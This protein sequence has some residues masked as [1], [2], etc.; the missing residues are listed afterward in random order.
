[1]TD[2]SK[3]G[4][5]ESILATLASALSGGTSWKQAL[6]AARAAGYAGG[7][8]DVIAWMQAGQWRPAM[9]PAKSEAAPPS[10]IE[11]SR[12]QTTL[13]AAV[14]AQFDYGVRERGGAYFMRGAVRIQEGDAHSVSAYVKGSR[15]YAV[16]LDLFDGELFVD[17]DCPYFADY[18]LCKHIW[19]TIR[20]ADACRYVRPPSGCK[21]LPVTRTSNID[22]EDLLEDGSSVATQEATSPRAANVVKLQDYRQAPPPP[23]W[24]QIVVGLRQTLQQAQ[25][26]KDETRSAD[27]ELLYVVDQAAT[28][29]NRGLVVEVLSRKRK[30]DGTLGAPQTRRIGRSQVPQ[31]PDPADRQIAALLLGGAADQAS[32]GYYYGYEPSLSRFTLPQDLQDVLLPLLCR[33]GRCQLRQQTSE[34]APLLQMDVGPPWE[35]RIEVRPSP[36]GAEYLVRG[37]LH[38]GESRR[39]L[40]EPV[41]LV[42]GGWVFDADR[43]ARLVDFGAFPW[44]G[45]LRQ[46]NEMRVPVAQADGLL[47]EMLRFEQLPPLDLPEELRFEEVRGTPRPHLKVRKAEH[48]CT[49]DKVC[50]DLSFEYGEAVVP[51][52]AGGR[53]TF[54]AERRQ[55]VLRDAAAEAV[56]AAR[57]RQLGFRRNRYDPALELT[58]SKLPRVVRTLVAENWFV[59][60]EGKLYR[61]P[62][63][64]KFSVS[65]GIDWFELRGSLDFEGAS[66]GLPALLA[67]VRK[68]G[69]LVRLDDGSFGL[70]PEEWL[71]RYGLLAGTGVA[72]GDHLRFGR[73][74]AGLLDA[75]LTAQPQADCDAVFS[76][77]REELRRFDAITPC[78][79]PATFSGQLRG[80]QKDGLGWLGFLQRFGFGGCLADDMGLGKTVQVLALLE[81]RRQLR[82]GDGTEQA[83]PSLAVVPRSLI[84]NWKQEAARFTPALRVLDHTGAARVKG[85]HEHFADFD[86]VLTTYGTLLRDV[87]HLRD[88]CFDYVVLDEAQTIKNA[89]TASA[90]AARLLQARHRLCLSGTPIENHVGELWSLFEFLNPGMLGAA[91]VFELSTSGERAPDEHACVLLS[92]AL[93]SFILR[94]TKSQVA[95]DLPDKTEQTVY[96]ELDQTQRALYNELRQHYRD[97]LLARVQRDGVGKAKIQILEALLR[98]RQAAC[99]PGLLDTRRTAESSAKL[100]AL[101]PQLAEVTEEGHKVLV[102]SQFTK[103]LAI[104][105][106]RLDTDRI[107]YEYLDGKTRD[108]EAR[109]NRFQNDPECRLFLISL[110]AGGLGLNLTA[111]EYVFLLDPWWNPAVEAQ[112]VD[113][114]HRIGQTRPVFAY[115]LIARDT[116][117]EKVLELQQTKRELADAIINADNS[118]IRNLSREDLELLLG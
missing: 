70:L 103:F 34:E 7:L 96:C 85:A 27:S 24:K 14:A 32:S 13:T 1:V 71:T 33:S 88:V 104:V 68:G 80:Y 112:A 43:V 16:S 36:D 109:V 8:T 2:G 110:K 47:T 93:R 10:R 108:R 56:A 92:R 29:Q 116:V 19:A 59:E 117:E 95:K 67:A 39:E 74:Q 38:R 57:L 23:R 17:C 30:Q 77:V 31:L 94:R 66:V 83:G 28:M 90:K 113:R 97:A 75:L 64:F 18:G 4:N 3:P 49:G 12:P 98:L 65:S 84:F 58:A 11:P 102:F 45:V 48:G 69:N 82:Q 6:E 61:R 35:F 60:A 53:G 9:Q 114:A 44:I 20:A 42:A 79:P 51:G 99:H 107:P 54:V 76:R 106:Q 37:A 40:S 41:M 25:E 21:T 81:S 89:D 50:G 87:A 115:R 55:L 91:S 22:D 105:R 46:I 111:A 100:E 15:R 62:G 52:S 73:A 118:L 5:R 101:L 86:L 78:E 26:R 72:N 63:D